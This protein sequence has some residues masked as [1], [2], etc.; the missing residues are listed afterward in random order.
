MCLVALSKRS[1]LAPKSYSVPDIPLCNCPDYEQ[2]GEPCKH[3][4]ALRYVVE[5]ETH[6]DGSETVTETVTVTKQT[7]TTAPRKTYKQDWPAYN[8]CCHG[9]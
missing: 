3:V 2:R 5:R 1:I 7:K 9:S 6:P 4:F 8:S